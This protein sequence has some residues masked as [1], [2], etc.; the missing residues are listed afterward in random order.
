MMHSAMGDAAKYADYDTVRKRLLA[1]C[2]SMNFQS[3]VD[4]DLKVTTADSVTAT[5]LATG[6][7]LVIAYKKQAGTAAEKSAYDATSV[8]SDGA[9]LRVHFKTD[10]KQFQALMHTPLFEAVS[11]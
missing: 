6:L 9:N 3:G 8:D 4:F 1:S 11:H 10:D 5:S 7:K 2:Y